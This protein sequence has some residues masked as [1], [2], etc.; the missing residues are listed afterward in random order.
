VFIRLGYCPPQLTSLSR[1]LIVSCP[2][3]QRPFGK[4]RRWGVSMPAIPGQ[5][6]QAANSHPVNRVSTEAGS[7]TTRY[8]CAA[9]YL[10]PGM[11]PPP[12]ARISWVKTLMA[13]GYRG[14][15]EYPVG[16][17]YVK[18]IFKHIVKRPDRPVPASFGLDLVPVVE[19]CITARRRRY[20]R[21]TAAMLLITLALWVEP[22]GSLAWL[23]ALLIAAL[24]GKRLRFVRWL[25]LL[26]LVLVW[27][28]AAVGSATNFRHALPVLFAITVVWLAFVTER[29]I[30][31]LYLRRFANSVPSPGP[32]L[33]FRRMERR[34]AQLDKEQQT[35]VLRLS[36]EDLAGRFIGAGESWGLW[37]IGITLDRASREEE[38]KPFTEVTLLQY[39]KQHLNDAGSEGYSAHGV[40]MLTVEE[41][42]GISA[43]RSSRRGRS[44]EHEDFRHAR[45][46]E[47]RD[48]AL[49]PPA[50]TTR[51]VYLCA[52][53]TSWSSQLVPSLFVNVALEGRFLR[54]TVRPHVLWPT[55]PELRVVDH[56][57]HPL[58]PRQIV[59]TAILAVGDLTAIL[60]R[61]RHTLSHLP[62]LLPSEEEAATQVSLRER[63][64][65][66]SPSDMHQLEDARRHIQ[67]LQRRVFDAAQD[68][69]EAHNVDITEY[70][71]QA[72]V[73]IT[74]SVLVG[75][76]NKGL[77][78]NV[79]GSNAQAQA[80]NSQG[81][82]SVT[83]VSPT[84]QR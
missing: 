3:K 46:D 10:R 56:L 19:H 48:L 64:S 81:D 20:V 61:I 18:W 26:L 49:S 71:A 52:R 50:S 70:R 33:H 27:G 65:V 44:E 57:P 23:V 41:L 6:D 2:S 51:R 8:L 74:N 42:V 30:A 37:Q 72:N 5:R 63:F 12:R 40:P 69:L 32:R 24:P 66:D 67:L 54:L 79:T 17:D 78:Q 39:I 75:G 31:Q 73:V 80:T 82:S 25:P 21:G 68:F 14:D 58:L 76:D 13:F 83:N 34:I 47:L 45:H 59:K 1:T 28:A 62:Q 22:A 9:A 7:D 43:V 4:P 16:D 84:S 55:V 15:P 36:N 35:N 29:C 77:V 11:A 60:R 38:L 53:A